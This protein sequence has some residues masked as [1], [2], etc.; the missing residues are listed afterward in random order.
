FRVH[1]VDIDRGCELGPDAGFVCVREAAGRRPKFDF[2]R[3]GDGARRP[4]IDQG[5]LAVAW[6]RIVTRAE[7]QKP[8][9][10]RGPAG[11]SRIHSAQVLPTAALNA[12]LASRVSN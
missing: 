1:D 3:V 5:L 8:L 10:E 11:G 9:I 12:S 4:V 6:D 7:Q 2:I